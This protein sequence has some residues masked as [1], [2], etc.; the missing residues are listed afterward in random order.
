MLNSLK[1]TAAVASVALVLG[2]AVTTVAFG[3]DSSDTQLQELQVELKK[4]QVAD[5]DNVA[6]EEIGKAEA[7]RDKA[8]SLIGAKKSAQDLRWSLEELEAVVNLIGAKIGKHEAEQALAAVKAEV[9]QTQ[10]KIKELSSAAD[11]LEKKQ[12]DLEKQLGGNR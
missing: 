4:L 11:E 2:L 8:R 7:L 5:N 12:A 9:A 10:G 1:R 6:T 3:D